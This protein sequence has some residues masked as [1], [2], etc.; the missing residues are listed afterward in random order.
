MVPCSRPMPAV[1]CG[2]ARHGEQLVRGA[3]W[4][5][6]AECCWAWYAMTHYDGPRSGVSMRWTTV[7]TTVAVC[8]A[9]ER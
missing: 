7:A 4:V 9:A 1:P 3:G 2:R 8:G 6:A 5:V